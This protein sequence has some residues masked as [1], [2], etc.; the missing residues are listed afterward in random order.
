MTTTLPYPGM[1]GGPPGI[2]G[3]YPV[4]RQGRV[5]KSVQP[6]RALY[7]G[8]WEPAP[9]HWPWMIATGATSAFD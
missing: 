1:R 6:L 8:F 7:R 5:E 3:S 2:E 9:S 4:A